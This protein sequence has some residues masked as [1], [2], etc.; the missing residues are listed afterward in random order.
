MQ[1]NKP[2]ISVDD[3]LDLLKQ[4]GLSIKDKER[5]AY[6]LNSVSFFRLTAYMRP[7]QIAHDK[8]HSFKPGISFLH[9][10]QLYDFDRRLRLLVIDALERVEVAIRATI[11]N[12]MGPK[13]GP[14]WYLD[15]SLF[16]SSYDHSRLLSTISDIQ[17]KSIDDY[18]REVSRIER[19][20][21]SDDDKKNLLIK[22]RAQ[23]RYARHYALTY[24]DPDLMPGWAM[25]EELTLGELSHL[26][27]G[28]ALDQ[29]RKAIAKKLA[30]AAPL[31]ESWL[32]TLT[33]IRNLCAHHSRL[34]NRELG[35]KP[36]KPRKKGFSWPVYLQNADQQPRVAVVFSILHHFM[37]KV[38]PHSQWHLSLKELITDSRD[39]PIIS[40]GL[41]NDWFN[42]P[43]WS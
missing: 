5:A 31:L 30:L 8:T 35:I 40:M 21:G 13:Y 32:H 36:E 29:D 39:I 42:D 20:S 2:A 24:D 27:K 14:H 23:E 10:S 37:Q 38:S 17:R 4:R 41:P 1:F 26:Y 22:K 16:K 12:H 7:F 33:F 6:F 28:I 15:R 43:F 19:L 34:W 25:V 3:Q 18:Q 11:S 9:L